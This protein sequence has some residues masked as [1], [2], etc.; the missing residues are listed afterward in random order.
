MNWKFELSNQQGQVLDLVDRFEAS[1]LRGDSNIE[2]FAASVPAEQR[3]EV[4]QEIVK[5]DLENHWKQGEQRRVADYLNTFP[6]L[7]ES[8]IAVLDLYQTEFAIRERHGDMPS[9]KEYREL[10]PGFLPS[11]EMTSDSGD[12]T[13]AVKTFDA[14]TE[15]PTVSEIDLGKYQI[16]SKLGEGGFGIVYRCRDEQLG[17]TVAIKVPQGQEQGFTRDMLHEAQTVA[18][19]DHPNIVRMLGAETT[20]DGVGFLVYEFI[21]GTSL[22]D[23]LAKKDCTREELIEWIAQIAEALHYAHRKNVFHRDIKPGNILIDPQGKAILVD[24]GMARRDGN[25]YTRDE[26]VVL[27]TLAYMPPEQVRG[28]SDL[29]NPET[30]LYSLG[31][32]LYEALCGERPFQ[33]SNF[34]ELKRQIEQRAPRSPRSIDDSIPASLEPLVERALAKDPLKRI[35]TGRDFAAELRRAVRPRNHLEWTVGLV[36]AVLL[37]LGLATVW[38]SRSRNL[39]P[40]TQLAARINEV[41]VFLDDGTSSSRLTVTDLPL[42]PSNRIELVAQFDSDTFAYVLSWD[43]DGQASLLSIGEEPVNQVVL[44]GLKSAAG[45]GASLFLVGVSNVPLSHEQI[46]NL[47]NTHLDLQ[48]SSK[49]LAGLRSLF[50]TYDEVPTDMKHVEIALRSESESPTDLRIPDSFKQVMRETF[51]HYYG[52][53]LAQEDGA[54]EGLTQ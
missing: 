42:Q 43:A 17:R 10:V 25:F 44:P 36:A 51:A 52:I 47:R 26:G 11:H 3:F 2:S 31:V 40:I 6:E 23:R 5:I 48:V 8:E 16:V 14:I 54:A 35:R 9:V 15:V 45:D 29:A 39:E 20:A 4:L 34:S 21:D 33:G 46:E 7:Q 18:Q 32:V 13:I 38:Y 49:T 12:A 24:F 30:D 37:T 27:G 53:I 28:D 41:K 50:H 22:A 19:L 1:W